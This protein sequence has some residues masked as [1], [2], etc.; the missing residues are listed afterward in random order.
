MFMLHVYLDAQYIYSRTVT[1]KPIQ[2]PSRNHRKPETS[3]PWNQ[4][5]VA[6]YDLLKHDICQLK[7]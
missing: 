2:W 7:L 1:W 4:V 3:D 6:W 5:I